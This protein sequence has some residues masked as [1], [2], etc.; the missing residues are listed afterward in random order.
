MYIVSLDFDNQVCSKL[1]QCQAVGTVFT[2][3]KAS[4]VWTIFARTRRK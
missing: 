4:F 3:F 2:S 1:W